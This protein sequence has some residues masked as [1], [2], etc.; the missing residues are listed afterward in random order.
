[1]LYKLNLL[2]MILHYYTYIH[3]Y[4]CIYLETNIHP[5][6][7]ILDALHKLTPELAG[8]WLTQKPYENCIL[9][10][11]ECGQPYDFCGEANNISQINC[12]YCSC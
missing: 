11:K 5:R 1:M 3:L 6:C 4:I 7:Y 2:T 10:Q 12:V 8:Q 9:F